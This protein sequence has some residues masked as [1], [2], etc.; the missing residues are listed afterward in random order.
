M[1]KLNLRWNM[2]PACIFG[3][4]RSFKGDQ[5]YYDPA[6]GSG[7]YCFVHSNGTRYQVYYIGQS[8]EVG[9]RLAQHC[10]DY[11]STRSDYWLPLDASLYD[12]DIY[13]AFQK[14]TGFAQESASFPK[15]VRQQ[16]GR[17]IMD[18]TY[19]VFASVEQTMLEVAEATLQFSVIERY[20]LDK[21][22]YLGEK[23]SQ[24]PQEDFAI[25]QIFPN[26]VVE[27]MVTASIPLE[28]RVSN[29]RLVY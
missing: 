9:A 19:F 29:G 10:L 3:Y 6:F 24:L 28:I 23:L 17:K 4:F 13:E 1:I 27:K 16:V 2:I 25:T 14:D 11:T 5:S 7:V 21:K 20:G 15:E 26:T 12:G 18:N 8:K 22:G